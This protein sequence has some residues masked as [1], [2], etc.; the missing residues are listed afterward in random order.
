MLHN[1]RSFR[2]QG[3]TVVFFAVIVGAGLVPTHPELAPVHPGLVPIRLIFAWPD[4]FQ[5][6]G[7][8]CGVDAELVD[9][10]F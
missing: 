2:A 10:S 8:L 7:S 3:H 1:R 6:G 9:H 5:L 4:V